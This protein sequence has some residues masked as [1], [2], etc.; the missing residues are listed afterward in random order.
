MIPLTFLYD[1]FIDRPKLTEQKN[2]FD[3]IVPSPTRGVGTNKI[4]NISTE[5]NCRR[6]QHRIN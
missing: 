2:P 4:E 3:Y 6:H 5:I 1:E